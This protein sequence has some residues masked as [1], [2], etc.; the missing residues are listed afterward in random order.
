MGTISD[1][2]KDDTDL[3][4]LKGEMKTKNV[5]IPHDPGTANLTFQL[6]IEILKIF[7]H[8][9]DYPMVISH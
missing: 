1:Y 9:I 4:I 2:K 3:E 8:E 6:N 7:L 5:I